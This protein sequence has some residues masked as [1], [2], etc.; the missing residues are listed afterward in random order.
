MLSPKRSKIKAKQK[1]YDCFMRY[2]QHRDIIDMDRYG[3]EKKNIH[4]N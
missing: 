2:I 1:Q 3:I 4:I